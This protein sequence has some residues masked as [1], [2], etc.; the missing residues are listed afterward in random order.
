[1]IAGTRLGNALDNYGD[2]KNGGASTVGNVV[3]TN[4]ALGARSHNW[5]CVLSDYK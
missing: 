5:I 3:F 4:N 1:M 2:K